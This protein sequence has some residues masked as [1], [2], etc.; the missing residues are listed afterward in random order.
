MLSLFVTLVS[1]TANSIAA[2]PWSSVS[3]SVQPVGVPDIGSW[4]DATNATNFPPP[5]SE[6]AEK[7]PKFGL[8]SSVD[9]KSLSVAELI[10]VVASNSPSGIFITAAANRVPLLNVKA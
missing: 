6:L 7:L 3:K 5:S 8:L 10:G 4:S 9:E 1:L 2:R